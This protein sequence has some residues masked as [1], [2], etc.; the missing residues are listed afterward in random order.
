MKG[1]NQ[2]AGTQK[3]AAVKAKSS[4]EIKDPSFP[5]GG[6]RSWAPANVSGFESGFWQYWGD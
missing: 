6:L 5:I 2:K 3:K 4:K 1:K